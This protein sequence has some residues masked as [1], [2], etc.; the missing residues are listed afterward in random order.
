MSEQ[1]AAPSPAN[2]EVAAPYGSGVRARAATKVT[3]RNI[4]SAQLYYA[5]LA[6]PE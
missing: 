2:P 3:R 4:R 1:N 6:R 5:R